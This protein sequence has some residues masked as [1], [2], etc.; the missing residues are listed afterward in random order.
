MDTL[1]THTHQEKFSI[2]L[3]IEQ[4]RISY[5][6]LTAFDTHICSTINIIG[7]M[8]VLAR[9]GIVLHNNRD[10]SGKSEEQ[11]TGKIKTT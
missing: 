3:K 4:Q 10:H 7:I 2:L 11:G 6:F 8:A 1:H 9:G 5:E